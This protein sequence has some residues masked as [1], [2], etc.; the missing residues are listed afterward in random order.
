MVKLI[1][2]KTVVGRGGTCGDPG[3]RQGAMR[4]QDRPLQTKSNVAFAPEATYDVS[5]SGLTIL[6]NEKIS[7]MPL[8]I[9]RLTLQLSGQLRFLGYYQEYILNKLDQITL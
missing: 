5:R 6:T 8:Y 2:L 4:P 7:E 1:I 9:M 3:A